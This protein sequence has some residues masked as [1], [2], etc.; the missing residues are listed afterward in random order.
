MKKHPLLQLLAMLLALAALTCAGCHSLDDDDDDD[1]V[2]LTLSRESMTITSALGGYTSAELTATLT[3][4]SA[5]LEWYSTNTDIISVTASGRTATLLCEGTA[6]TVKVGVRTADG[7]HDTSCKVKVE[8]SDTPASPVTNVQVTE[9]SITANGFTLTWTDPVMASGVVIDVFKTEAERTTANALAESHDATKP[10]VY[11]TYSIER[12]VGT[13]TID[14]LLT[15]ATGVTYYYSVYGYLNGKRSVEAV[16]GR[17]TLLAD[18]VAPGSVTLAESA[19]IDDHTLTVSWT[20]PADEDYTG[21]TIT[22]S[23]ATDLAGEAIAPL[24][25]AKGTTSASFTKL[26]AATVYTLTFAT[27]DRNG[28]AQGDAN[29][30]ENAGVT[31]SYTTAAD[32]TAPAAVTEAKAL[33]GNAK[34]TLSWKDPAELDVKEIHVSDASGTLLETVALGVQRHVISSLTNG[35]E[36]SYTVTAYDYNDNASAAATLTAT[37]SVKVSDVTATARWTQEVLVKWTDVDTSYKY[38]VTCG[39][40]SKTIDAGV[41]IAQF[42]GLTVGTEYSVTVSTLDAGGTTV[43]GT[44]DAVKV[45]PKKVESKK[46]ISRNAEVKVS[47][48]ANKQLN[49]S[50]GANLLCCQNSTGGGTAL[51]TIYPALDGSITVSHSVTTSEGETVEAQYDTFSLYHNV[52]GYATLTVSALTATEATAVGNNVSLSTS[53]TTDATGGATFFF[54]YSAVGDDYYT[55]RLNVTGKNYALGCTDA[56]NNADEILYYDD[57]TDA[58]CESQR[59]AWYMSD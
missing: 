58:T 51:W 57:A 8:L 55:L 27:K 46:I 32:T 50:S 5:S 12:G 30:A 4:S 36:Y 25:V 45:T 54:G 9:G 47:D 14:D 39:N 23:P 38:K 56:D 19:A 26:S 24:T 59:Y 34:V 17:E 49:T 35:T 11:S 37:P 7:A 20:E 22:L 1:G 29:N 2:S 28:N 48:Q 16:N 42:T 6:G 53:T 52:K 43:L 10:T 18:R 33:G 13:Y 31:A 40:T 3:G 21:V 15:D 41:Q 44:S